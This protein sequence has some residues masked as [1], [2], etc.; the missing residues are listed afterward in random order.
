MVLSGFTRTDGVPMQGYTP[1][2]AGDVLV[3]Q[4]EVIAGSGLETL[5]GLPDGAAGLLPTDIPYGRVDKTEG[6]RRNLDKRDANVE[7]FPAA[8]FAVESIR[9]TRGNATIFCGEEQFSA[10][11]SAADDVGAV[12]RTQVCRKTNPAPVNADRMVM[13]A[14]ELAVHR[15]RPVEVFNGFLEDGFLEFPLRS[16]RPPRDTEKRGAVE[17]AYSLVQQPRRPGGGSLRRQRDCGRGCGS[18]GCAPNWIR[19][20][21]RCYGVEASTGA[22]SWDCDGLDRHPCFRAPCCCGDVGGP[23]LR[24]GGLHF[25]LECTSPTRPALPRRHLSGLVHGGD[26]VLRREPKR[27]GV[28]GGMG[29]DYGRECEEMSQAA[30][31]STATVKGAKKVIREAPVLSEAVRNGVVKVSD[32]AAIASKPPEVQAAAL[33]LVLD[34]PGKTTLRKEAAR[35]ER[36]QAR[37]DLIAKGGGDTERRADNAAS[38]WRCRPAPAGESGKRGRDYHRPAV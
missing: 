7:T 35:V 20:M 26:G 29:L 14:V 23:D 9:V 17:K 12:V 28:K 2:V 24:T 10:L 16:L 15:R 13:S 31:V 33:E 21:P 18:A 32:A 5:P 38:R 8:D 4:G 27:K 3:P 22:W 25:G 1:G 34:T 30:R 6:R 37:E 19:A 11:Y 36:G